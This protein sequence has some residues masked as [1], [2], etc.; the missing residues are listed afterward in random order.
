MRGLWC[1]R[2]KGYGVRG[3]WCERQKGYGVRGSSQV[4][5]K[6]PRKLG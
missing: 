5:V 1:E 3:L 2:Q 4:R 6:N